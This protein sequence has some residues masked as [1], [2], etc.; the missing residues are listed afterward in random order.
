[1]RLC[2]VLK[3][4]LMS[5]KAVCCWRCRRF[6]RANSCSHAGKYFRLPAGFYGLKTIFLLLAFMALARLKSIEALRYCAPGESRGKLLGLDCAPEV[7]TL[8]VKVKTLADQEQAF[9]WSSELCKE[10]MAQAPEEAAVL[11]VDGHVRVYY[12]S[13]K[14][15]PKHYIARERL[16]L[17]ATADY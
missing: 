8:R 14:Q 10:W 15:L 13:T 12:G 9:S 11:Y 17:S 3:L 4:L 7:R 6:W 16:C 5:P 1:M 2:L